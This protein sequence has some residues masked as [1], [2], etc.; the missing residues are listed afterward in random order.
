MHVIHLVNPILGARFPPIFS[1]DQIFLL[2][3][4]PPPLSKTLLSIY[5]SKTWSL[6]RLCSYRNLQSDQKRKKCPL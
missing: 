4:F 5:G 3:F 6:H 2:L 1:N